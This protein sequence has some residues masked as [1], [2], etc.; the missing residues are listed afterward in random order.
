MV[1]SP[2]LVPQT[3]SPIVRLSLHVRRYTKKTEEVVS[4]AGSHLLRRPAAHLPQF[5]RYPAHPCRFVALSTIRHRGQKW[6]I[7]L[8]QHAV[9][10]DPDRYLADGLGLGKGDV[11][12]KGD[13]KAAVHRPPGVLP[14]AGKTMQNAAQAALGPVALNHLQ[15]VVPRIVATLGRAAMD[16]NWPPP[17][18]GNFHLLRKHS[19][20]LF[21]G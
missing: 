15:G 14:L 19:L 21:P 11:P 12:R 7:C 18:T 8:N 10:R 20:L 1:L 16:D 3:R 4:G 17:M 9:E 6:G 2:R 13:Q 5:V